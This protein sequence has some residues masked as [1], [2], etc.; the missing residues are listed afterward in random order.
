MS[1]E[2]QQIAGKFIQELHAISE[3]KGGIVEMQDIDALYLSYRK[4][5]CDVLVKG[6]E[7]IAGKIDK[8]KVEMSHMH[9]D[10]IA[11]QT[12]DVNLE[13]DAVLKETEQAANNIMDAAEAIQGAANELEPDAAEKITAQVMKL[14][15]ACDFQD[16]TGQRISKVVNTLKDV[17]ASIHALMR[18][19]SGEVDLEVTQTEKK[20]AR[21]DED[22]MNGPQLEAPSQEDIDK[23]FSES[24]S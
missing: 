17:D 4:E 6:V 1:L 23:L 22:L 2:E 20:P 13:L 12:S 16:I 9:P 8:V 3:K 21:P 24:G 5:Q 15:E 18:A 11:S 10:E 7:D 19:L 14:F